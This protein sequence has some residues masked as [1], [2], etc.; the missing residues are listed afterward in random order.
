MWFGVFGVFFGVFS[1]LQV[2][3][4]LEQKCRTRYKKKSEIQNCADT[5]E[6]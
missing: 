3:V 4:Y 5:S 2:Y 6:V 1:V